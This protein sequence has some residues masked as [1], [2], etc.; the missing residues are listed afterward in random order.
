MRTVA[1]VFGDAGVFGFSNPRW[2][3]SVLFS[4]SLLW[5]LVLS[6]YIGLC[7]VSTGWV[8]TGWGVIIGLH[9]VEAIL[10]FFEAVRGY[11]RFWPFSS[12]VI[13]L[14][15]IITAFAFLLH[16][17]RVVALGGDNPYTGDTEVLLGAAALVSALFAN[18]CMV[19]I[20]WNYF[21]EAAIKKLTASIES[22]KV[23]PKIVKFF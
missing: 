12:F 10:V 13:S 15:L 2:K 16:V 3:N 7:S 18:S 8:Q 11:G 22:A 5:V 20:L 19:A 21:H 17:Q 9:L 4:L 14:A 1:D 6:L 23:S